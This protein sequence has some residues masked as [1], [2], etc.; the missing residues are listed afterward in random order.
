MKFGHDKAPLLV[1]VDGKGMP[2]NTFKIINPAT[3][4]STIVAKVKR[5]PIDM[6]PKLYM[7]L[8]P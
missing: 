5:Q 2:G 8:Y 6:R 1:F 3:I 4:E 7:V